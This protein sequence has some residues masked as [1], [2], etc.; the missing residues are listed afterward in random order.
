MWREEEAQVSAELIIITAALVAVAVV[1]VM[2]LQRTA[3]KGSAVLS[4]KTEKALE[5]IA[6]IR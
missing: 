4:E 3:S 5:E 6:S 1:L 2:Q